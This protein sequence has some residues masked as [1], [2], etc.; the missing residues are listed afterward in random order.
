MRKQ[1]QIRYWK[2]YKRYLEKWMKKITKHITKLEN[3]NAR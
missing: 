3:Q 2:K 1:D